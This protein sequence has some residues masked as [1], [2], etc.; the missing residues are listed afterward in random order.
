MSESLPLDPAAACAE[1]VRRHD[2]DRYLTALFAPAVGRARLFALYAFNLEIARVRES[3]SEPILGAVRLRFWRDA[4]ADLHAGKP[5]RHPVMLALAATGAAARLD[6]ARLEALVDARDADLRDEPPADLAAL[7]AYAAATGGALSAV[8]IGL[9]GVDGAASRAAA[10]DVGT[11]FA[12]AGLLRAVPFHAAARRLYLP[13]DRLAA[14]GVDRD[15]L[16]AGKSGGDL[17][18]IVREVAQT[19]W[20]RLDRAAHKHRGIPRVALPVLLPAVLARR[21]LIRLE[22]AGFDPFAVASA[23]SPLRRQLALLLF[24]GVG[25]Y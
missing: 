19:A 22:R 24:A 10:N 18:L 11:A 7:A 3:V 6:P 14:A 15:A 20:R 9:L 12:L 21:D 8:A 25:R 1:E 5:P 16:F 2:N 13:A 17:G 23:V 4:L